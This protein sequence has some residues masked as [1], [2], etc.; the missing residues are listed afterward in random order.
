MHNVIQFQELTKEDM[1][2]LL[3][4]IMSLRQYHHTALWEQQKHF[5]WW[6]SIIIGTNILILNSNSLTLLQKLII[7]H[8]LMI[9]G[10]L[11]TLIALSV[12]GKETKNF[13]EILDSFNT[14]T[15]QL[16]LNEYG[17][18]PHYNTKPINTMTTSKI[19]LIYKFFK[20]QE[21]RITEYFQLVFIVCLIVFLCGYFILDKYNLIL[22]FLKT[23]NNWF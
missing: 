18:I 7:S 5:T 8:I 21:L 1:L 23:L 22:I 13:N 19:L 20:F 17:L 15:N 10:I 2:S 11:I 6:I 14:I 12:L 16:K 3:P 9:L 4:N